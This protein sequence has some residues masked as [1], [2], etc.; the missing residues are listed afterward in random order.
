MSEFAHIVSRPPSALCWRRAVGTFVVLAVLPLVF[1]ANA[2]AHSISQ[3]E[4][5][6]AAR[7]HAQRVIQNPNTDYIRADV[8]C[9]RL[10]PHIFR[11]L[12]KFD[13]WE[14]KPT[15]QYACIDAVEVYY[16]A[17]SANRPGVFIKYAGDRHPC[18]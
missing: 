15:S 14:T 5:D 8:Q 17:H 11:C 6:R 2:S 1:A 9:R 3:G 7:G 18:S 16:K 13:T 10:Y 12:V 4:A